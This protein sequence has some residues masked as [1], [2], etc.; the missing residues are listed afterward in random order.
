[1]I[2]GLTVSPPTKAIFCITVISGFETGEALTVTS[3]E[4]PL[5]VTVTDF[6]SAAMV[7]V[8]N[9]SP[10]STFHVASPSA[11]TTAVVP[12]SLSTL[13]VSQLMEKS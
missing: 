10:T 2:P 13:G 5:D 1:M 6:P 9:V 3:P 8:A 12:K 4:K 7:Y 11:V